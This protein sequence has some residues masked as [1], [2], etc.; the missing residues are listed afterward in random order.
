VAPE[1]LLTLSQIPPAYYSFGHRDIIGPR[2]CRNN[3]FLLLM[4]LR[5]RNFLVVQFNHQML[6]E[7]VSNN[8]MGE[9]S[10]ELSVDLI[11]ITGSSSFAIID[12][13]LRIEERVCDKLSAK[14]ARQLDSLIL[15]LLAA[16]DVLRL[17]SP[18]PMLVQESALSCIHLCAKGTKCIITRSCD[19]MNVYRSH[20]EFLPSLRAV[21]EDVCSIFRLPIYLLRCASVRHVLFCCAERALLSSRVAA[22]RGVAAL[23]GHLGNEISRS[24]SEQIIEG[25]D[26]KSEEAS[27]S[28]TKSLCA[29]YSCIQET[30]L[31]KVLLELSLAYED[32]GGLSAQLSSLNKRGL[33]SLVDLILSEN[34][35][36]AQLI[37]F[38]YDNVTHMQKCFDILGRRPAPFS[39]FCSEL[40][41]AVKRFVA[42][43]A[44]DKSGSL[45][46]LS[47]LIHNAMP[48]TSRVTWH[49]RILKI[50]GS[51]YKLWLSSNDLRCDIICN[52]TLALLVVTFAVV[53]NDVFNNISPWHNG[54]EIVSSIVGTFERLRLV[55]TAQARWLAFALLRCAER[56]QPPRAEDLNDES[57]NR[58]SAIQLFRS[59][60]KRLV[61][62]QLI[63][64]LNN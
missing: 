36:S 63:S 4:Q 51:C 11:T 37:F 1:A 30:I 48:S 24:E 39:R 34:Y 44:D 52:Q 17:G 62:L 12:T 28:R 23:A 33:Q 56:Q 32:R 59:K 5:E 2:T 19:F 54:A 7:A 58:L 6:I 38:Q 57:G 13:I 41:L 55:S 9:L 42:P 53:V 50:L 43:P 26:A 16:W 27:S 60:N 49:M 45:E 46:P 22:M 8:S 64:L 18:L 40:H 14:S 15:S 35:T 61:A 25:D 29:T 31:L 21:F 20:M 10:R 47:E 3:I